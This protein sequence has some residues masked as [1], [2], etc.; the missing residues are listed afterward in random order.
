MLPERIARYLMKYLTGLHKRF[1]NQRSEFWQKKV[2]HVAARGIPFIEPGGKRLRF[3]ILITSNNFHAWPPSQGSGLAM[4][5]TSCAQSGK[6]P[7]TGIRK[8]GCDSDR[9]TGLKM[10]S[11]TELFFKQR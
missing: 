4:L 9:A 8:S 10:S 5:F 3:I 7:S 1:S 11:T 6:S 2:I